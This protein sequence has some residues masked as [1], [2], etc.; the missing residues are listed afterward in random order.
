MNYLIVEQHHQNIQMRNQNIMLKQILANVSVND[1][2]HIPDVPDVASL[3]N[4]LQI[5]YLT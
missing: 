1:P 2:V 3:E 4:F 5:H